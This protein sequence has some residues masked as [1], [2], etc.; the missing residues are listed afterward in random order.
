MLSQPRVGTHTPN[1]VMK[2]LLAV[3]SNVLKEFE[4]YY[5]TK[6][7][8][9]Q[10]NL[11]KITRK[12][13]YEYFSFVE[14]K[15][16]PKY[17][18]ENITLFYSKLPQPYIL[19]CQKLP[20]TKTLWLLTFQYYSGHIPHDLTER[21]PNLASK[22][23]ETVDK[24]KLIIETFASHLPRNSCKKKWTYIKTWQYILLRTA[25]HLLS[26]QFEGL[27]TMHACK[28]LEN[29]LFEKEEHITIPS[30]IYHDTLSEILTNKLNT[31][32]HFAELNGY[33]IPY[34]Q[35]QTFI[36]NFHFIYPDLP[37]EKKVSV[38]LAKIDEFNRKTNE[39]LKK[40]YGRVK[41]AIKTFNTIIKLL[42]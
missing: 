36:D 23:K 41:S 11:N 42:Q 35:I 37:T 4:T 34:H 32:V 29:V 2:M 3:Q 20:N 40:V 19:I 21:F 13:L 27:Q 7:P 16:A 31:E 12:V 9:S 5:K 18:L 17:G 14:E 10:L 28:F 30:Y 1:E 38:N 6:H 8:K 26:G 25:R 39:Y 22:L 33:L 15:L 24:Y